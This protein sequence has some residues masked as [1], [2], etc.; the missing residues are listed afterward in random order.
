MATG[1]ALG[2]LVAGVIAAALLIAR[3][4]DPLFLG[5]FL[6]AAALVAIAVHP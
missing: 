5:P 6:I 2:F 3:R 4:R 1:L